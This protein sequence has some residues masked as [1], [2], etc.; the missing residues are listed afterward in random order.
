M[1]FLQAIFLAVVQGITEFLP[2]SSSAH[3]VFLPQIF[4]WEDQGLVFDI[5]VHLGTLLAVILYFWRELWR[6]LSAVLGL[7]GCHKADKAVAQDILLILK[8]AAATLPL[9]LLAFL[10]KD[11]LEIWGRWVPVL[12]TSSIV[13]GIL[14]WW[15]DVR[16]EKLHKTHGKTLR[17]VSWREALIFGVM[18]A[19]AL[20]PGTSRS[21]ICVTAGRMLG[22]SREVS[23]VFASLLAIPTILLA[24]V[25][26]LTKVETGGVQWQSDGLVLLL[27]IVVSALVALGGIHVL[28]TWLARVGYFPFMIY[29]VIL[30][31]GLWFWVL[32]G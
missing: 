26:S 5:A 9:V 25:Y 8:L 10:L 3:L 15:M 23:G 6:M 17:E 2:V 30:G 32:I 20:I 21:G 7:R 18:Q 28:V 14:L 1:D 11:G 16:V 29:R 4:G 31:V 24:A 22:Y 19:L 12:A 13:F 27:G